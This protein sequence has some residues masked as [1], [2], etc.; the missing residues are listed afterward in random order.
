M[1]ALD[2]N[3]VRGYT[4]A[5]RHA[6]VK[7]TFRQ[8]LG[9]YGFHPDVAEPR[10]ADGSGPDICFQLGTRLMLVDVT[11]VNPLAPTYVATEAISPGHTLAQADAKKDRLHTESAAAR[12][13]RFSPL[14][15]TVFGLLSQ[16]STRFLREIGRYTAD[17]TG[18]V[19]HASMALSVAVQRG[20]AGILHAALQNWWSFGVR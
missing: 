3:K 10:F 8:L 18:F 7:R 9:Q 4:W 16:K 6:L 15:L 12:H 2:C 19:R 17:P 20:N 11:I 1:H 14:A 5:S 13:M